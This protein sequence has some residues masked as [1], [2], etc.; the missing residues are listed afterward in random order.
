MFEQQQFQLVNKKRIR[1]GFCMVTL[2]EIAGRLIDW[3]DYDFT[4]NR[5]DWE[6]NRADNY[7]GSTP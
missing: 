5:M 3:K 6:P 4:I 2:E 7:N 1:Y